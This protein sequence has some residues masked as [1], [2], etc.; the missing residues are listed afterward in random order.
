[1]KRVSLICAAATGLALLASAPSAFANAPCYELVRVFSNNDQSTT[2][3]Y[4]ISCN[5]K[6][7]LSEQSTDIAGIHSSKV[8][9]F[10]TDDDAVQALVD[11]APGIARQDYATKEHTSW[12]VIPHP[13]D[14]PKLI[15]QNLTLTD[16]RN[17]INQD[18]SDAGTKLSSLM[19]INCS[20]T[21]GMGL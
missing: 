8:A 15:R 11:A 2:D 6:P 21:F 16:G 9:Q 18:P 20:P 4:V 13:G 17:V 7:G 12:W 3:R 5:L 19:G 10:K 1:M 14:T